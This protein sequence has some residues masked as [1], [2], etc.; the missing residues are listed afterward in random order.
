MLLKDVY[1]SASS[2]DILQGITWRIEP[3]QKWSLVGQNGAGKSS[4]LKAI[5]AA[6]TSSSSSSTGGGDNTDDNNN[7]GS[8]SGIRQTGG[9]I[10]VGTPTKQQQCS[11]GYLPQTAVAKSNRTIYEEAA[12]GMMAI[13]AAQ[14]AI[15]TAIQREDFI[16]LE[17]A[18]AQF[19]AV[20]G[21][22]QEQKVA[23]VLKGLGFDTSAAAAD[24]DNI[25][26]KLCSELSGGWQMRVAFAK[27]LL[28]EP[29]LCLMDEPSNH[30]DAAAKKWLAQYLAD[31]DGNGSMILVTH[32]VELLQSMDHI[33]E[34]IP[35]VGKLQIYKSCN[36]QQYLQL[37]KQRAVAA[38]A[39]YERNVQKAAKLQN[40]VDRFGA[41]ATKASAAQSRV[42]QLER[43]Q[44]Q[45]LLDAPAEAV[46]AQRFKPTLILPDP[47]RAIGEVL[48]G[49]RDASIGYND[50]PLVSNI[51]L[52]ITK[53][54]K[55]LVRG[56]N[57]SGKS[58]VLKA[59]RGSLP[60]LSGERN[61]NASLRLGM[62]T[63][64][65]AQELDTSARA[66]DIATA[67]AREGSNGD[68]TVSDE[69]ARNIMGRLG[70]QGEKPLRK[71]GDL[72]GGEKARVALAMF[73]LK[74]S[75][76]YLLDEA[77]NHLDAECVEA[78]SSALSEWGNEQGA[79]VV[80]SHDRNFCD[81]I[82]FSHVATVA[83][84]TMILEQRGAQANDWVV[85]EMAPTSWQPESDGKQGGTTIN[86]NKQT[87]IDPKLRKQAFNAPKRIAK[88]EKMIEKAEEKI[89][90]LDEEMLANGSDVGKLVDLTK[91]KEEL[92]AKVNEH[93]LEWEELESILAQ[94]A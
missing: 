84:G 16:A 94:I 51:N 65:L 78:L 35:G 19:E 83:N 18:T 62:F 20:G 25:K 37:K 29:S 87:D 79:L 8:S 66:V 27:L 59:L 68:I 73:A 60:L 3:K 32:D 70:L 71:V 28:S 56:P 15:E 17:K 90:L 7:S 50:K 5:I 58:T 26:T 57:G 46:V 24:D 69:Q 76:L 55:L 14:Q 49:L 6:T 81:K 38:T 33:A 43:M 12:S 9:K 67:Y 48:I 31:Y 30:L 54:M 1:V 80:V 40:F 13:H 2:H 21:Y 44:R 75:N 10:M 34:L 85:E 11:I 77:S 23:T 22:Q 86:G 61:E 41:S 74:P 42:K 53:G 91:E 52:E 64:D 63:Q 4:L 72:S 39:E 36:Y 89:A 88:L 45:G 82:D 92:E 93:M 47:P